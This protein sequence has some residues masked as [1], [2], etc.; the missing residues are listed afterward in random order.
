MGRLAKKAIVIPQGVKINLD[1]QTINI[2][3][4][5]GT[6]SLP[7]PVDLS[8]TCDGQQVMLGSNVSAERRRLFRKTEE[9]LGLYRKLIL[10]MI[11]GITKEFEK[12]LEIHGIGF[13]AEVKS[14]KLV[15]ELGFT[16]PVEMEI[17]E[18]ITVD[19]VK[20]TI[21]YVRGI[22]KQ[23]VGN[24]AARVRA[25]SPP[26]SYKG[27]GIRYRGEYVRQKVGKAAAGGT[28]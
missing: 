14:K 6:L 5:K 24:F 15:L 10:N 16:H 17:P 25:I 1:G 19:V 27:T 11:A 4:A 7:W 8:V 13:K 21:I 12:I 28:K 2:S 9:K 3:G 20:N 23:L 26:E 22:D 18:G